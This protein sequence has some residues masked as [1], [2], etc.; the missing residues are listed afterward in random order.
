MRRTE[1]SEN[2]CL[3][4]YERL[5]RTAR[6]LSRGD[7]HGAEDLVQEVMLRA[8]ANP[9]SISAPGR[10]GRTVLR[11]L[12]RARWARAALE[13]NSLDP[14]R[15]QLLFDDSSDQAFSGPVP[16]RRIREE[17][18]RL[19]SKF[20]EPIECTFLMG[21]S[22]QETS[23]RLEIPYRTVL[24]RRARGLAKLRVVLSAESS[25]D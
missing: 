9:T 23:A 22:I 8:V 1:S 12:A 15:I 5:L 21:L 18:G 25:P 2:P 6:R 7:E 14:V 3:D 17:L 10:W 4:E 20:R 24:S 11:N 13:P 19:P 16:I